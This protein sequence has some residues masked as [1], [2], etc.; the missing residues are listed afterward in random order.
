MR[1]TETAGLGCAWQPNGIDVI[2][3]LLLETGS[4]NV[5]LRDYDGWT[6][7]F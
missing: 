4:V 3:K 1:R 5:D 7:L 2:V 6:P